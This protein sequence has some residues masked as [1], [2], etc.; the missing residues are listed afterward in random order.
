MRNL[1]SWLLICAVVDH[2]GQLKCFLPQMLCCANVRAAARQ[3]AGVREVAQP[4]VLW[5][6]WIIIPEYGSTSA[7]VLET[8]C[9]IRLIMECN[10]I[11]AG[12]EKE[13]LQKKLSGT[14]QKQS[15]SSVAWGE[16]FTK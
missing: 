7:D 9:S 2:A 14:L 13:L 3:V 8:G 4:A 16:W 11:G 5:L 10:G 15:S 12:F 1:A 6:L